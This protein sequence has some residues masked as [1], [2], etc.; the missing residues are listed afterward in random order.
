LLHHVVYW[1]AGLG[2]RFFNLAAFAQA[3]LINGE[4]LRLTGPLNPYAEGPIGVI[5]PGAYADMILVD[6]NPIEDLA[7]LTDT[8]RIDLVMKDGQVYKNTLGAS[9]D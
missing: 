1:S 4:L 7:V 9:A 3:T 2:Q 8:S 5:E 6:G